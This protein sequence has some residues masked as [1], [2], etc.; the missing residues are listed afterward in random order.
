MARKTNRGKLPSNDLCETGNSRLACKTFMESLVG[1]PTL[2]RHVDGEIF[3]MLSSGF[4]FSFPCSE[5]PR[6]A[7]ATDKER[8]NMNLHETGI[9]WPDVDEDLSIRSL[10][11]DL[12]KR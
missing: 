2:A 11:V 12:S 10:L 9:H 4:G 8:A 3:V 6:L 7:A 1:S 5:Y